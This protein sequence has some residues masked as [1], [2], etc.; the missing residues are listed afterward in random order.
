MDSGLNASTNLT[1][2]NGHISFY[3]RTQN[4][5]KNGWNIGAEIST[6]AFELSVYYAAVAQKVFLPGTYPTNSP[7][8]SVTNTL[9]LHIGSATSTTSY[10]LYQNS[11]LLATNT[12][13]NT[14]ST[15]NFNIYIGATNNNGSAVTHMPHQ[16]AF[17]SIGDGL[18]D[19]QAS[20][21]Y[22]AVQAFQ[23]TLLRQ[24]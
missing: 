12:T 6:T 16:C 8:S 24:V 9:G 21:F 18:T 17:A 22:T 3:S 14:F 10:K 11:S 15:P 2:A 13:L 4:T 7:V 23:T 19:T 5:T 20:N 1:M